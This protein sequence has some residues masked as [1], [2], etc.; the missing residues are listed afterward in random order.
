[1]YC[2][3]R[4]R[5]SG[6]KTPCITYK[7][8]TNVVHTSHFSRYQFSGSAT[9]LLAAFLIVTVYH[10]FWQ[11]HFL[12]TLFVFQ[13]STFGN[14]N[15]VFA[16]CNTHLCVTLSRNQ[17][18]KAGSISRQKCNATKLLVIIRSI[19]PR[20]SSACFACFNTVHSC[21]F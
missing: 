16:M 6:K 17:K 19:I 21:L 7:S 8:S 11:F 14:G 18:Y 9:F 20:L 4:G 1:M 3:F 15:K 12:L 13:I 2:T 5:P 10:F